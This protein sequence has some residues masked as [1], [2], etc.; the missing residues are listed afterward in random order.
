MNSW[1]TAYA[2]GA[3]VWMRMAT[4]KYKNAT[5]KIVKHNYHIYSRTVG[6]WFTIGPKTHTLLVG[7]G[8]FQ[9]ITV[10]RFTCP[11]YLC[12]NYFPLLLLLLSLL[13]HRA[14]QRTVIKTF[15]VIWYREYHSKFPNRTKCKLRSIL[16]C[17][18]VLKNLKINWP[19]ANQPYHHYMSTVGAYELFRN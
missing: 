14:T 4:A 7:P 8:F 11:T 15:N 19:S 9:P 16:A 10:I 1:D 12:S 13:S 2:R 18:F 5:T 6:V 17:P 3:G